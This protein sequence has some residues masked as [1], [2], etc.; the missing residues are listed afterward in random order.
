V[1]VI[2]ITS[3]KPG[4]PAPVNTARITALSVGDTRSGKTRYAATWPRPLVLADATEGGWTTIETMDPSLFYE[5]EIVPKVW[6]IENVGD[7]HQAVENARPL[8]ASGQVKTIVV[9]SITFLADMRLDSLGQQFPGDNRKMYG[10]LGVELRG[11][12]VKL[13]SL[14]CNVIWE[15]LLQEADDN[16]P[17]R[18]SIPGNQGPKFGAGCDYIFEFTKRMEKDRGLVFTIHTTSSI[19]GGRDSGAL[20][21]ILPVPTYRGLVACLQNRKAAEPV[22]TDPE[23][24]QAIA[25]AIPAKVAAPG[26]KRTFGAPVKK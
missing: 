5:P 11:W 12:R 22:I 9:S 2:P 21:P 1:R 24:I 17:R 14:N 13:H 19:A 7:F 16:H 15:A 25:A 23:A 3:R 20:P 4:Q 8:I 10:Q 6:A 26:A 18:P